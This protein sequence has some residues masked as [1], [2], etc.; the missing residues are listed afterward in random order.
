MTIYYA[1]IVTG[2]LYGINEYN[3]RYENREQYIYKKD[4]ADDLCCPIPLQ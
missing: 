1:G 3:D 2:Y 4:W